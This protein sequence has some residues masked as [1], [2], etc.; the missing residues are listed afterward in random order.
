MNKSYFKLTNLRINS[1][2]AVSITEHFSLLTE[3]TIYASNF[4][5]INDLF[6]VIVV[7]HGYQNADSDMIGRV[8]R[9]IF[10]DEAIVH[11]LTEKEFLSLKFVS[12]WNF[13]INSFDFIVK[14]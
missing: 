4:N 12:V 6:Y 1:N 2:G 13:L 7:P 8:L 3:C 5:T 11:T 9:D 10:Q 14:N